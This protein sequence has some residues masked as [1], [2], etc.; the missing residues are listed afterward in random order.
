MSRYTL[1]VVAGRVLSGFGFLA[2]VAGG[3]AGSVA[4]AIPP[5]GVPEIDPMSLGSVV[6]VV[7]GALA[8]REGIALKRRGRG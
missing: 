7:V 1:S 3:L 6:S 8:I 4:M 5:A 2:V